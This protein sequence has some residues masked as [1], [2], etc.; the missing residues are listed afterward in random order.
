MIPT[1]LFADG[2]IDIHVANGVARITLGASTG[3]QE[4]KPVPSG[5]LIVPVVQLP[6]FARV[7]GEVT[8]QIEQRT[9]DAMAQSQAKA[10][11]GAEATPAADGSAGAFRFNG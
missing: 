10:E 2:V 5:V 7:F 1:T 3:Q 11:A 4:Q 6:I 9:K 8:R